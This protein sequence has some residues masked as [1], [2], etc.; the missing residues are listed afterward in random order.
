[1]LPIAVDGLLAFLSKWIHHSMAIVAVIAGSRLLP[2][3]VTVHWH[4]AF[5]R[6]YNAHAPLG[7]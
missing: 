7:T 3:G 1:M 4:Q 6:P 2:T 5:R